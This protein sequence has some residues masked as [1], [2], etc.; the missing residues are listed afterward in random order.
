MKPSEASCIRRVGDVLFLAV[1]RYGYVA[2]MFPLHRLTNK[3]LAVHANCDPLFSTNWSG[4]LH[5]LGPKN[6]S[7]LFAY[8]DKCYP[9]LQE[10]FS[11][12]SFI[13]PRLIAHDPPLGGLPMDTTELEMH[14]KLDDTAFN[15]LLPLH[16][17]TGCSNPL[18]TDLSEISQFPSPYIVDH[19][20]KRMD[21]S[22]HDHPI[23]TTFNSSTIEVFED[24]EGR[25]FAIA[26][27]QDGPCRVGLDFT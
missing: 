23:F 17:G 25:P 7:L 15:R 5:R 26:P 24:S 8:I 13:L 14:G 21:D 4:S 16:S 2:L 11:G 6:A 12:L 19:A 18:V 9:S 10:M 27:G 22:S 20:V 3:R 1:Q